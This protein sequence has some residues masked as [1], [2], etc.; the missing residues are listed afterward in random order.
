M[1]DVE[2]AEIERRIHSRL[3][4]TIYEVRKCIQYYQRVY[5]ELAAFYG[6]P[7]VPTD[8]I[9]PAEVALKVLE[10]IQKNHYEGIHNLAFR[11][12][13]QEL[14]QQHDLQGL[15]EKEVTE[16]RTVVEVLPKSL[17]DELLADGVFGKE[18]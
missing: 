18:L 5:R 9:K 12:F 17:T 10:L 4:Q 1:L 16:G 6:I 15:I 7:L 14:V 2:I 13:S 11:S 3:E 8:G